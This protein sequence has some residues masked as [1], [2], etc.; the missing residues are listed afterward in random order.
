[1]SEKPKQRPVFELRAGLVTAAVWE[2]RRTG[3]EQGLV[4]HSIRFQRLY[5]PNHSSQWHSSP[6][7][8]R[9]DLPK[10]AMLA[11]RIYERLIMES[12]EAKQ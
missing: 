8:N 9:D 4:F 11:N 7:L 6:F 5:R 10:V 12:E 3:C 2:D 1:M